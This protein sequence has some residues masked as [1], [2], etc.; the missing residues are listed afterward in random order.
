MTS[1]PAHQQF[2]TGLF[3]QSREKLLQD[4]YRLGAV[5]AFG[6]LGRQI[7]SRGVREKVFPMGQCVRRQPCTLRALE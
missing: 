6:A 5:N 3:Q 7:L 4:E 2:G 1:R